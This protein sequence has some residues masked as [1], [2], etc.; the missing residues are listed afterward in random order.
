MLTVNNTIIQQSTLPLGPPGQIRVPVRQCNQF[1]LNGDQG[2]MA[3]VRFGGL[4]FL[5]FN[6]IISFVLILEVRCITHSFDLYK[7]GYDSFEKSFSVYYIKEIE[8]L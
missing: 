3:A 2:R 5:R 7:T 1:G 4:F 8:S 6:H